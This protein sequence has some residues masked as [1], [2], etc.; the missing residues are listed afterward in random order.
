MEFYKHTGL[1]SLPLVF[2]RMLD[3]SCIGHSNCRSFLDF[4]DAPTGT[5]LRC[6]LCESL[7]IRTSE[8]GSHTWE[9]R[10]DQSYTSSSLSISLPPAWE[11]SSRLA[12]WNLPYLQKGLRKDSHFCHVRSDFSLGKLLCRLYCGALA[13][14][15]TLFSICLSVH[16]IRWAW[17][18]RGAVSV[19]VS[20]TGS[21]TFDSLTQLFV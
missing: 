18:S 13:L 17:W 21:Q 20:S 19:L 7:A 6:C 4:T 2:V 14:P 12:M 16:N 9:V 15:A 8:T 5:L 1:S 11:S 10:L 3:S